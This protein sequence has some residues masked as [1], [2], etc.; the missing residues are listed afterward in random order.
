MIHFMLDNLRHIPWK[1]LS[2][3]F[4][5]NIE[6]F[7]FN[8]LIPFWSFP[9]CQGKQLSS[10]SYFPDFALI[11]GFCI[12]KSAK[13]MLTI[14]IRF[15]HPI[16]FAAMPTHP[17]LCAFKVSCKSVMTCLIRCRRLWLLPQE[18]YIFYNRLYH[19]HVPPSNKN[20]P[21]ASSCYHRQAYAIEK[22]VMRKPSE[23]SRIPAQMNQIYYNAFWNH[24]YR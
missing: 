13:P 6:I 10:V 14:I 23:E 8:I 1:F 5:G 22:S 16:M 9:T 19:F 3:L 7:R 2:L 21:S 20:S 11:T 12:T 17:S 15:L 18:H 4:E 24:C